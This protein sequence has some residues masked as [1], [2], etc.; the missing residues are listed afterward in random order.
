MSYMSKEKIEMK[1]NGTYTFTSNAAWHWKE[2]FRREPRMAAAV[3][4]LSIIAVGLPLLNARLP[5]Q[6]LCGL[7]E[8]IELKQLV[9]QVGILI[10][11]L[12]MGNMI[13]S[14]LDAYI[15]RMQGPFED[16]FNLRMLKKR[17]YVDYNVLESKK[18]NDDAHAV[19]DSLYRNN[20]V[21]R[22]GSM[23]SQRF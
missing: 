14:A 1:T 4:A 21:M 2:Q 16:D 8:H 23:I 11:I 13:K 12:A 20:S 7:E 6:V 3:I 5:K 18:F 10:L 15:K 22:D 9:Q 19:F 17:L